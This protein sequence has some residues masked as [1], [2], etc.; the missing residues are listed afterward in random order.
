MNL[1]RIL[2]ENLLRFGGKNLNKQLMVYK[3]LL[4]QDSSQKQAEAIE[5]LKTQGEAYQAFQSWQ[6][7]VNKTYG[8]IILTKTQE[9]VPINAEPI[10]LED[11]FYNNFVT[12]ETGVKDPTALKTN[13][14]DMIETLKQQGAN[15][16]DPKTVIEIVSTATSPA[17]STGPNPRDFG[18]T[19]PKTHTKIDHTYGG[20]LA[21]DKVGKPTPESIKW[22][23]TNGNEYLAKA[24]GESV[25]KYLESN[26][27]KATII[28][29]AL[30]DQPKREF[31][32]TA[33]QEGTDKVI[34][35]IGVPDIEWSC[36]FIAQLKVAYDVDFQEMIRTNNS[37]VE[38]LRASVR[39]KAQGAYTGTGFA[40][41]EPDPAKFPDK[42]SKEYAVEYYFLNG[43]VKRGSNLP[44]L[45]V[46]GNPQG[47]LYITY[48]G[49]W[50]LGNSAGS[51]PN[52]QDKMISPYGSAVGKID[53]A[54]A[55]AKSTD[56]V[57]VTKG[58]YSLSDLD[59]NYQ[60]GKKGVFT[61]NIPN[62]GVDTGNQSSG[63]IVSQG[64]KGVS[65]INEAGRL[66]TTG[67]TNNGSLIYAQLR[68]AASPLFAQLTGTDVAAELLKIKDAALTISKE[69][70]QYYYGQDA[71][72]KAK[73]DAILA[74]KINASGK[75]DLK[76]LIKAAVAAGL[77]NVSETISTDPA[78]WEMA[79]FMDFTKKNQYGLPTR[80]QLLGQTAKEFFA[81]TTFAK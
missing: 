27:V 53:T 35:P 66:N 7:E 46:Y 6:S 77:P 64:A 13:L 71:N 37:Q 79:Y 15:M 63:D 55:N 16:T 19:V 62:S 22:A 2:A 18:G 33:K 45:A 69:H 52:L 39:E 10:R 44:Y 17:A 51:L 31:V 58:T 21:Y 74:M 8:N 75:G 29:I 4:E 24:R 67:Y 36:G 40:M 73:Y 34:T 43:D 30:T 14:D 11:T 47:E 78:Y 76:A 3:Y 1:E 26:G 70:G 20:N 54:I 50:S 41:A 25:K 42:N 61:T 81:D 48:T 32:I 80:G 65:G 60:G 38:A 49:G 57:T 56:P 68:N 5:L 59:A 72:A 23:Q 12:L 9:Y 28:V